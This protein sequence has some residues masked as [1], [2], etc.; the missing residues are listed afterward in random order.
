M[1]E[2]SNA[3]LPLKARLLA[4]VVTLA[5]IGVVGHSAVA[6]VRSDLPIHWTVFALITVAS[7]M[8]SLKAPAI[9]STRF[10][11]SEAFVFASVLLFGPDVGVVTLALDGIRISL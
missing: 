2:S 4:G 11:I 1:S 8:L 9:D 7:G 6:L 10:S 5:G 3:R